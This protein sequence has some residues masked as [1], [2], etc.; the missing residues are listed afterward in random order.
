MILNDR[1]TSLQ[2]SVWKD[3]GY[4]FCILFLKFSS[5][6]QAISQDHM[7]MTF[8][9]CDEVLPLLPASLLIKFR[10]FK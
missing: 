3:H 2:I 10:Y 8:L 7:E 5:P 4:V 6:N 9:L 1:N